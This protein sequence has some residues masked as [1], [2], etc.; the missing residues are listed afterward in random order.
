MNSS[1]RDERLPKGPRFACESLDADTAS[2]SGFQTEPLP[3]LEF[4][5]RDGERSVRGGNTGVDCH[6]EQHF[7]HVD[8]LH[9]MVEGRA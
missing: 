7:F 3:L 9:A 5:F 2:G 8:G 4:F 6:L 1:L